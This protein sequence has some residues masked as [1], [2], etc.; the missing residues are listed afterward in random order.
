MESYQSTYICSNKINSNCEEN[1][2]RENTSRHIKCADGAVW[3]SV[4]TVLEQVLQPPVLGSI[5]G[6][7]LA[8]TPIRGMFVD[9]V[10][11][12]GNAPLQ[13]MFD[14]LYTIGQTA[15]PLTMMIL[16]S[17]LS[18][19]FS[20]GGTTSE[21]EDNSFSLTTNYCIVIGKMIVLPII[22]V[23]SVL[24]LKYTALSV[25]GSFEGPLCIVMLIE[26]LC[27]TASNVMIM[28]ELSDSASK[29]SIAKVIAIQYAVAPIILSLTMT[30]TIKVAYPGL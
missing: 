29:E 10:D 24:V 12:N 4:K 21:S 8:M 26:F 18:S 28:L 5:S 23:I 14:G 15:V 11:R 7:V 2:I 16:G 6:I 3:Q 25:D 19:S 30:A 20:K 27:P 9:I 22:G 17:N 1:V 13:W